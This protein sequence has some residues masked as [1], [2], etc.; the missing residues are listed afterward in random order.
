MVYSTRAT[1]PG[2]PPAPTLISAG[3]TALQLHWQP[4]PDGGSEITHYILQRDEG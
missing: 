3:P 1:V 2:D 4:P